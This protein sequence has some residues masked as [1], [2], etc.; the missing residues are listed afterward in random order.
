[1]PPTPEDPTLEHLLRGLHQPT[2]PDPPARVWFRLQA[3]LQA[4]HMPQAHNQTAPLAWPAWL[5]PHGI[6]P[7]WVLAALAAIALLDAGAIALYAARQ[8]GAPVAQTRTAHPTDVD[9]AFF[10]D[11]YANN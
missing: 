3:R 1:M 4:A 7:Q 2:P 6:R 5:Q 10:A 11:P 8:G 9:N